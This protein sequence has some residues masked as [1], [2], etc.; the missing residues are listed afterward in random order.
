M[1]FGIIVTAISFLIDSFL[2][3]YLYVSVSNNNIFIPM[4]TLISLI[5]ILPYFNSQSNNYLATCFIFG[6]IYDITFTNTLLLNAALF[7]LI[8]FIIILLDNGL[9]NNYFNSILKMLIVIIIFDS[10]T[11][12][13]LLMLNYIN[14]G[15]LD[16]LLKIAKSLLL[17]FIY[18]SILYFL[19]NMIAKKLH[20]KK[21]I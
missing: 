2:S 15:I 1:T 18:I 10:L 8:G 17:N 13:I 3:N 19:T 7:T 6:L 11:Y 14:Y 12:F 9:S 16:L 20:I 5:I 21:S 4:F